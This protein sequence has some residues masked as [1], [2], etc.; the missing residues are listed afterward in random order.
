MGE[1]VTAH[2]NS[3][4]IVL[5]SFP[6]FALPSDKFIANYLSHCPSVTGLLAKSITCEKHSTE[7]NT[8]RYGTVKD[9]KTVELI[10]GMGKT[11]DT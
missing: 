2:C 10:Y 8:Q 11:K 1:M 5:V 6:D 4:S 9:P 7:S 3:V